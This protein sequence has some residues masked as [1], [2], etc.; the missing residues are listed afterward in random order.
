MSSS[1][2]CIAALGLGCQSR[3]SHATARP[4]RLHSQVR[5]QLQNVGGGDGGAKLSLG[6]MAVHIVRTEG[7]A[8]LMSGWQA[9][10]MREMSYSG[11]RMGL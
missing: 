3:P 5:L 7:P 8:A 4:A 10:V 2:T 1:S 9:S 6:R 11:I